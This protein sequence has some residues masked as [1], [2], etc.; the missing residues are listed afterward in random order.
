MVFGILKPSVKT[1]VPDCFDRIK[2]KKL[3]RK[4]NI[5]KKKAYKKPVLIAKNNPTGN[6]AAGCPANHT[7]MGTA[8]CKHCDRAA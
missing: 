8:E 3:G 1:D 5:M 6:F 2:E 7:G 4:E